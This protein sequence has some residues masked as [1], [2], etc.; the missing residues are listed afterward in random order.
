MKH[1]LKGLFFLICFCSSIGL[2]AAHVNDSYQAKLYFNSND[3]EISDNVIYI[4]RKRD[5]IP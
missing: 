5:A 3:L 1:F 2:S 4:E